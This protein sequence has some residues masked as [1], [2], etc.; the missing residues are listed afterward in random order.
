MDVLSTITSMF[1]FVMPMTPNS[2]FTYPDFCT[3][4]STEYKEVRYQSR[5]AICGREVTT[6]RKN[7]VYDLY[8]IPKENRSEYTID[9]L[10]PLFLGGSNTVENLWP[11]HKSISTVVIEKQVYDD[12]KAERITYQEALN[13][14]LRAKFNRR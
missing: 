13:I 5:V 4:K 10:V 11:Q 2:S 14:I 9:H 1:L 12:L 6:S 3:I 7:K 8:K